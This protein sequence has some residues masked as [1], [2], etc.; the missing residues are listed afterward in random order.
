M[1]AVSKF[2]KMTSKFIEEY[3]KDIA[4]KI[5]EALSLTEEQY[6]KLVETIKVEELM[7]LRKMSKRGGPTKTRAPT[8][9]NIFVQKTIKELKANNEN[10]DRK[11]LMVQAAA[12]WT[13]LKE[14]KAKE[15]ANGVQDKDVKEPKEAKE[16]KEPKEVEEVVPV[17]EKKEKKSKK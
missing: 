15:L 2:A 5:K 14:A 9:Y 1:S 8:A 7:D 6:T 16:A 17:A 10:M 3:N 13:A 4:L 12:A 11:M